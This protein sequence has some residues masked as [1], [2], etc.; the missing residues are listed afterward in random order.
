MRPKN[1]VGEPFYK[2]CEVDST[3]NYAMRQVQAQMAEHGATWFAQHQ[4]AGKGQRGKAWEA[5]FGENIIMSCVLEPD[6]LVIDNQFLLNATVALACFDFFNIYTNGDTSIKWPNDLYWKDRKAGGI[7]I[8]NL[9]QG[10]EW[11]FAVAGIGININQTL[12]SAN[13]PNPVSLKEITGKSFDV[14]VLAKQLCKCLNY[15]WEQLSNREHDILLQ[16]YSARLYKLGKTTAFKRNDEMFNAVITGV[17]K[18]GEL[19]IDSGE[20][21]SLA[22]GSADWVVSQPK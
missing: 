20:R 8:E 19:L 13:L 12:F 9:V 14:V 1:L 6:F 21:S 10:K 22:Y 16:E 15:R 4:N 5:G 3:N 11:R 18:L 7:L 17:N 2:L